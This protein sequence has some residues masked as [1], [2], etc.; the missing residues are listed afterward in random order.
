MTGRSS[1]ALNS[2]DYPLSV[3]ESTRS[4]IIDRNGRV[5]L[6]YGESGW[7]QQRNDSVPSG[8]NTTTSEASMKLLNFSITHARHSGTFADRF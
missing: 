1:V 7:F 2:N 3:L 8:Y 6:Y 5:A 4:T